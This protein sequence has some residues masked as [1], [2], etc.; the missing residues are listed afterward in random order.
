MKL[1]KKEMT[2]LSLIVGLGAAMI[3]IPLCCSSK[4]PEKRFICGGRTMLSAIPDIAR[5]YTVS[6]ASRMLH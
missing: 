2:G 4:S 1:T 5:K 6:M 3:A